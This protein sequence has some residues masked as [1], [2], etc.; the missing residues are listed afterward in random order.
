MFRVRDQSFGYPFVAEGGVPFEADLALLMWIVLGQVHFVGGGD[1]TP[2]RVE[3]HGQLVYVQKTVPLVPS[4]ARHRQEPV[5]VWPNRGQPRRLPP[6]VALDVGVDLVL[7]WGSPAVH[8]RE[9]FVPVPG[10]HVLDAPQVGSHAGL[11]PR[12]SDRE[13][14]ALL[15]I[16]VDY[17]SVARV[18]ELNL[19]GVFALYAYELL[20]DLHQFP[21]P[22]VA[23]LGRV[24][25]VGLVDVEVLLVYGEDGEAEDYTAVVPDGDTDCGSPACVASEPSD[26]V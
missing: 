23:V 11:E 17:G 8:R 12:G 13:G 4:V 3:L 25:G 18:L 9:E 14:D 2:P 1:P 19:Q 21:T 20:L 5:P 15:P 24:L 10:A 7:P 16:F 26:P 22:F 6:Y